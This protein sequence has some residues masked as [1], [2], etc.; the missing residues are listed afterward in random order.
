MASII[1]ATNTVDLNSENTTSRLTGNVCR[2][3]AVA[4]GQP[5]DTDKVN[6]VQTEATYARLPC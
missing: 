6:V 1:C 4:S 5:G 2:S 3:P